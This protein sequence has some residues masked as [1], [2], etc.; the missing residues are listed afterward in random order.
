MVLPFLFLASIF[1]SPAIGIFGVLASITVNGTIYYKVTLDIAPELKAIRYFSVLMWCANQI[2]TRI[3]KSD[4][5]AFA[6]PDSTAPADS[7]PTPD[8]TASA[9]STPPADSPPAANPIVRDLARAYEIFKKQSGSLGNLSSVGQQKMS[10]AESLIEYFRIVTLS[11][12]RHYNKIIGILEKNTAEFRALYTSLGEIDMAVSVLSYRKSLP[13]FTRPDFIPAASKNRLIVRDIYHPL[14]KH[15][16][17]NTAS[18]TRNSLVSGSN[19]SGKSTFIKALAVNAITAQTIHTCCAKAFQ[20]RF[21]LVLSSMAI[22]D[23]ITSGD[24][25]FIAEIKSLKRIID[26][27]GRTNCI[28]I[29]D[30]ILRGT[31]TIERI[32]ASTAVL[33]RLSELDCLCIVATHD[34]ELTAL[35]ASSYENYHFSERVT[36]AGVVFDYTIKPGSTQTKNAITLLDYLG[37]DPQIIAAA[38][39]YVGNFEETGRWERLPPQ[40]EI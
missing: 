7:S 14:L 20:T 26:R 11:N 29:I 28:C 1:I 39:E 8:L 19:A 35:L 34:V 9:D 21:A 17:C 38:K 22:R 13:F 6:A 27:I 4:V 33:K 24:S 10:E 2:V 25:Y 23:D 36:D 30:E 15:P 18:I 37:Y 5:G 40:I 12:I 31:N 3:S 32:A 16:V